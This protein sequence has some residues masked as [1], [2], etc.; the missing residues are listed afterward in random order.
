MVVVAGGQFRP[1][2]SDCLLATF[3]DDETLLVTYGPYITL[4]PDKVSVPKGDKVLLLLLLPD[5]G[6]VQTFFSLWV[7]ELLPPKV[8][9]ATDQ[10]AHR[11]GW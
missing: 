2:L 5:S 10:T 8:K 7:E 3:S 11:Y 6:Q 4:H 1:S 9:V